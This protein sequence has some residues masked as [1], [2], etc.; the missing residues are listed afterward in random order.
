MSAVCGGLQDAPQ[1][2]QTDGGI[3]KDGTAGGHSGAQRPPLPVQTA[4]DA[5]CCLQPGDATSSVSHKSAVKSGSVRTLILS[6]GR[7]LYR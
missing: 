3:L 2:Y 6:A 1:T 5:C 4:A 7:L